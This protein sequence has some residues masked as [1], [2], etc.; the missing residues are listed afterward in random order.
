[1]ER[2]TVTQ[3]PASVS[4]GKKSGTR[5]AAT[6][7]ILDAAEEVF[8]EH[9]FGGAS[10]QQIA[11]RAGLPKANLHY[12]FSTKEALYRQVVERILAIWLEAAGA[13][14][15]GDDPATALAAYIDAKMEVSREHPAGSKVW[16]AEIL[17]G[18]PVAQ[19]YLETTL[20]AWMAAREAAIQRWIDQ[21]L[22][23]PVAPRHLMY[24]IWAATQHYADFAHQIDTLN[25]GAPLSPEQWAAA[26]RD[27]AAM[28]LGGVGLT[29]PKARSP[30]DGEGA[31]AQ[32]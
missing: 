14:D 21:G 6:R 24:M 18:A 29:A 20:K 16:A 1:M 25:G 32:V 12:Y 23:R 2:K 26:K 5:R 10:M 15:D 28:V 9:G 22:M 4:P 11:D 31:G 19:Q 13:F 17:H 27:V 8:A 3:I 7:R 30:G